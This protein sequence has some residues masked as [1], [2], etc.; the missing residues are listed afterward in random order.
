MIENKIFV[1][2]GLQ[3]ILLIESSLTLFSTETIGTEVCG[4]NDNVDV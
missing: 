4:E 1:R 3:I 2:F